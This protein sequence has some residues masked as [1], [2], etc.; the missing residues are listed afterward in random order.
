MDFTEKTLAE[1]LIY[2]GKIVSLYRN[3]VRLPG[4]KEGVREI[5]RHSGGACILYVKQG[6]VALVKQFRAP[7]GEELLEIPAGKLNPGEEPTCAALRELEEETGVRAKELV[8]LFTLYPSPGFSDEKIYVFEAREGEEGA[9]NLDED[10]FL[11]VCYVPVEEAVGMI[12]SGKIC[13]A[14]T[15]AA[16]LFYSAREKLPVS[17]EKN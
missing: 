17:S 5:V 2:E 9:Q 10:E 14:K 13:D 16:L 15:V 4:G 7:Y 8:P 6:K 3:K 11:S 12:R 1:N